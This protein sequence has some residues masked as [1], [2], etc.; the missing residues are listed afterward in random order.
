MQTIRGGIS[1]MGKNIEKSATPTAPAADD[2]T[3]FDVAMVDAAMF[4][5]VSTSCFTLLSHLEAFLEKEARRAGAA[6]A[7]GDDDT[8]HN[9]VAQLL[10]IFFPTCR[11]RDDGGHFFADDGAAAAAAAGAPRP[12]PR[13][14]KRGS[15]AGAVLLRPPTPPSAAPP[16]TRPRAGSAAGRA[17]VG[18]ATGASW[19]GKDEMLTRCSRGWSWYKRSVCMC[20]RNV[21]GTWTVK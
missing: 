1:S 18:R 2:K 10:L 6:L 16:K 19:A 5:V 21:R 20:G 15:L 8:A 11:M 13:L 9:P 4:V 12:R 17:A 14:L 3:M 7:A